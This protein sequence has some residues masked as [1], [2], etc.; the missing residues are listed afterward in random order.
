MN[1]SLVQSSSPFS[2]QVKVH[3]FKH[4]ATVHSYVNEFFCKCER[5]QQ[6]QQQQESNKFVSFVLECVKN[7]YGN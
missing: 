2:R 7:L 3:T 5:S 6:K 1:Q 4:R